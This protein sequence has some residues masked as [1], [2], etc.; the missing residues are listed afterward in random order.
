M[1]WPWPPC[2]ELEGG[3]SGPAPTW[4]GA[5]PG[6]W[7][8]AEPSTC[9]GARSGARPGGGL[10]TDGRPRSGSPITGGWL[11]P[12]KLEA[13]SPGRATRTDADAAAEHFRGMSA[14]GPAD[15]ASHRRGRQVGLAKQPCHLLTARHR[16]IRPW[17][18][19]VRCA[20]RRIPGNSPP[21]GGGRAESARKGAVRD[22]SSAAE[23]TSRCVDEAV[24]SVGISGQVQP[25][26]GDGI[27]Q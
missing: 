1:S 14:I 23:R 10:D 19:V 13:T 25:A 26:G 24:K 21:D 9:P 11:A 20:L 5:R 3:R 4:P 7:P 17:R 27:C 22:A 16:R 18:L 2:G 6:T 8:G 12:A 15:P